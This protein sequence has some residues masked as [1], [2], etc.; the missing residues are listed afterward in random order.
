VSHGAATRA[1]LAAVEEERRRQDVK[2][3]AQLPTHLPD[4]TGQYLYQ[5]A[6][7]SARRACEDASASGLL[8]M[9]HILAEEFWEATAESDPRHLVGELVQV[10][11]TAVKWVET[12]AERTGLPLAELL[13][14]E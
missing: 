11:A 9:R 12:V 1:V 5:R 3:G 6:A 14:I 13:A 7:T 4:G 10:A 8:T 2:W